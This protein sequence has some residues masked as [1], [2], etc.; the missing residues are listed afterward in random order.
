MYHVTSSIQAS[1]SRHQLNRPTRH[2]D[3]YLPSLALAFA[4]W[5]ESTTTQTSPP[6][7]PKPSLYV[8][9]WLFCR[10]QRHFAESCL[11]KNQRTV[12]LYLSLL[13]RLFE[14]DIINS[15][16]E[17]S[18]VGDHAQEGAHQ[19]GKLTPSPVATYGG[20]NILWCST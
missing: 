14:C 20:G 19:N 8:P 2:R 17:T 4:L 13:Y 3:F 18:A 6:C 12:N 11:H 9:N 15:L 16:R 5:N 7:P 10:S 1:M